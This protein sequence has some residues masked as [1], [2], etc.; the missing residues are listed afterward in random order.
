MAE[1]KKATKSK[2][3]KKTNAPVKEKVVETKAPVKEDNSKVE[4]LVE[5]VTELVDKVV[6]TPVEDKNPKKHYAKKDEHLP[7]ELIPCKSVIYGGLNLNGPKTKLYYS[8]AGFGDVLEVEYQDLLAWKILRHCSLFDPMI[9]IE[10]EDLCEEWKRD[11][12][13]IYSSIEDVNFNELFKLP[14]NEFKDRLKAFP[15]SVRDAVKNTAYKMIQ[16]G[17]L[18]DIRVV[19]A[20][21]D[22]LDTELMLMI[23]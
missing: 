5:K 4:E 20:I 16:D 19:K 13:K 18:Y 9:I 7:N 12:G 6:E 23:K 14:I 10:D 21:D 1:S 15:I 2:S 8:W 22:V 3:V 17:T 11:L